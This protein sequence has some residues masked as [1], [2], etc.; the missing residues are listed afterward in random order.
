M[1]MT[2]G[3]ADQNKISRRYSATRHIFSNL[4]GGIEPHF[5]LNSMGVTAAGI[6]SPQSPFRFDSL[7]TSLFMQGFPYLMLAM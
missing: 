2:E 1:G 7:G 3:K 4:V 5:I 6:A